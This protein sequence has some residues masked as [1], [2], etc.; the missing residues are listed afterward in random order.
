[1]T[2][3]SYAFLAFL[4]I[5][6]GLNAV[7]QGRSRKL[8]LL[9][10]SYVFYGWWDWRFLSLI[11]VSSL[12][13]FACGAALDRARRPDRSASRRKGIL[14]VSICLNLGLLGFFKYFGFFVDSAKA[15][16]G[17]FGL[18][19]GLDTLDIV[20]PVGISFY[21][22]QTMSYTI[23]IFRGKMR[24]TARLDDFMLFVAFFPQLVAGP[25]ERASRLLPQIEKPKKADAGEVSSGL[26]LV[27][28]GLFYK[29][30][31]A[32]NMAP[33]V[34][35]V[36]HMPAPGGA[37]VATATV[38]FAFQIYGDF[39]GYSLIARG[40]ARMLGFDIIANFRVPYVSRSPSEFW[41]RWH[42]SLSSWLRDYL[43]IPLGGNRDG[44]WRTYRNLSLTMLLG[45]LWHGAAWTFVIW[46]AFHGL[47][48]VAYRLLGHSSGR[49][50]PGE[51][52]GTF[53][54]RIAAAS[55]FFAL[56]C[57]GWLIFRA[58]SFGQLVAFSRALFTDPRIDEVAWSSMIRLT[59]FVIPM[60]IV[61][62]I[63]VARRNLEPWTTAS[64]AARA[65]FCAALFYCVLLL[66]TPYS[67]EFIYFQF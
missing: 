45:G 36:F 47:L 26:E 38:A 48:L 49:G 9:A 42:V 23:D 1:M 7:L 44:R 10:A 43:Y 66:G 55:L 18:P 35:S 15:T 67:V 13:D 17:E 25:I 57:L 2:F 27:L 31:V 6:L 61:D 12:V 52:N 58:D 33:Y 4:P 54:G 24:S 22:F 64:P 63:R 62:G 19:W 11:V 60:L 53:A 40:V 29:M 51:G 21:T 20:L 41:Q 56:T 3:V 16:L 39:A 34:N 37:A 5:V 65:L 59:L 28:L 46:G 8:M 50:Q 32:D 14:A 30:V